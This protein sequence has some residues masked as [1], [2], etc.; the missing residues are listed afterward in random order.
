[1]CALILSTTSARNIFF[2]FWKKWA[3]SDQK[4]ILV[5]MWSTRHSCQILTKLEFFKQIFEKYSYLKFH[6]NASSESRVPCGRTD[7]Q[8]DKT[9]LTVVFRNFAKNALK[10]SSLLQT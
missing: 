10:H 2:H 1:M 5:F 3:K 6:E 9:R 4:C 7:R 8:T